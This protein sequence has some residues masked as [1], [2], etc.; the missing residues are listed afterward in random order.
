MS[1]NKQGTGKIEWTDV[2]WNPITGCTK[3][4]D[5]CKYCYAEFKSKQ[6]RSSKG[7][8]WFNPFKVTFHPDRLCQ[9]KGMIKGKKIFVCSMGDLFHDDVNIN[10]QLDVYE[11]IKNTPQHTYQLLTKRP[12]NMKKF[13]NEVPM[14]NNIWVG[15][16]VSNQIDADELLPVLLEVRAKKHFVSIEPILGPVDI[17]YASFT[18]SGSLEAA[19]GLDWVICGGESGVSRRAPSRA[20]VEEVRDQCISARIPFFFK[21]WGDKTENIL[22]GKQYH[23]FPK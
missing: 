17:L 23:E 10:W 13:L 19:E 16:S 18:G 6:L 1:L 14:L 7:Y 9:P 8:D 22:N 21:G 4:R 3:I 11:V 15:T 12:H 2:T 20:W 5:G